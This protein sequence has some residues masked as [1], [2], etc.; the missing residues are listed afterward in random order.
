MSATFPIE[1]PT[2]SQSSF[3]KGLLK[4]PSYA[5]SNTANG[6]LESL[7][8]TTGPL[9]RPATSSPRLI[10]QVAERM[11]AAPTR[12]SKIRARFRTSLGILDCQRFLASTQSTVALAG[13]YPVASESRK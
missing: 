5:G 8:I 10:F 1:S 13:V 4:K 6:V 7:P 12:I 3:V 2:R 11:M 9:P